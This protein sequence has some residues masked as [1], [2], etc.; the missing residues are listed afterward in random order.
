M[1]IVNAVKKFLKKHE[2]PIKDDEI[3]EL[4]NYVQEKTGQGKY[5]NTNTVKGW[6]KEARKEMKHEK[7]EEKIKQKNKIVESTKSIKQEIYSKPII[8]NNDN[9]DDKTIAMQNM[10]YELAAIR[11]L[12]QR[13]NK[14]LDS[15]EGMFRNIN[16]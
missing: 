7:K 15:I 12:M 10:N 3:K 14:Q 9:K 6:I 8:Q 4:K 1:E 11:Q 13:V 5:S 2:G 16:E